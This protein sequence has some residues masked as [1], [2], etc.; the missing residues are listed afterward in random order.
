M[1]Q[2]KKVI[3]TQELPTNFGWSFWIVYYL[4]LDKLNANATAWIVAGCI[5]FIWV[6]LYG[7]IKSREQTFSILKLKTTIEKW[8]LE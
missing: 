7:L 5:L 8:I 1:K 4:T 3:D 6:F 2:Q